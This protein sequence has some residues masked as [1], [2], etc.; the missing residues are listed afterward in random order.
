MTLPQRFRTS[1]Q[2]A[3]FAVGEIVFMVGLLPALFST[4]KP[5]WFTSVVTGLMLCSF[6]AVQIS[7]RNW[8]TTVLTSAT[9]LVW[10]ALAVQVIT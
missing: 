9:A 1:W 4:H 5:P 8:W 2:D 7:Y 3:V 10:F 6:V